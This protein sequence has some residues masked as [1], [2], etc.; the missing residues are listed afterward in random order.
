[1]VRARVMKPR[2]SVVVI[3]RNEGR[4]LKET[5][6]NLEDTLPDGGEIVVVDDGST[7]GSADFLARRRNGARRLR[8]AGL[9]VAGARNLG[10]SRT[11]GGVLVFADAHMSFAPGWWKLLVEALDD[12]K[13]AAAAPSVASSTSPQVFGYGFSIPKPDLVARWLMRE[14]RKPFAVPILPGCCMAIRRETFEKTG[15]FDEGLKSRGC[16]DCE[17]GVRLWLLGYEMWVVP[18]ARVWH[19]FREQAPYKVTTPEVLHNRLRLALVHLKP[20]RIARVMET[21]GPDKPLAEAL[22]LAMQGGAAE[23]RAQ[24]ERRRVRNDDWLFDRFGIRW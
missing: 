4:W 17:T 9:G 8:A 14:R 21:L 22:L 11:Q 24:L 6:G 20:A 7:D 1:M 2:I 13:V 19:R 18:E 12:P 23:R 15:G 16:V 3:S 5:I 10:A